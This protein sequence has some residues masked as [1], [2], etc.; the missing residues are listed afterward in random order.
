[1]EIDKM[2]DIHWKAWQFLLGEWAGEGG[3]EPGQGSAVFTF[4]PDL[5][6]KVLIRK[7]HVDYPATPAQPAWF[8]EDL[9]IVYQDP[10]NAVRAI[11]FD[12]E[13]HVIQYAVVFGKEADSITFISDV[14][15][16]AP[17]FR[18]SYKK[19][20][21]QTLSIHFEIAPP[22]EPDHFSVYTEGTAWRK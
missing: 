7:N 3:G 18:L 10:A 17:R 5:Q 11:Y 14:I 19:T 6:Q 22:N 9:L 1:M 12:N 4:Y 15:P 20:S 13:G 21:D 2:D 8:H 16:M